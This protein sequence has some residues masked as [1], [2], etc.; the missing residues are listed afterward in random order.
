MAATTALRSVGMEERVPS[1]SAHRA[2]MAT[3]FLD[4]CRGL[5]A[6]YVVLSHVRYLLM[7][8]YGEGVAAGQEGIGWLGKASFAALLPFRYGHEA[9]LFFFILSGFVI[10]L[11]QA[12]GLQRDGGF[13]LGWRHYLWRRA[14]RLYPPLLLAIVVSYMLDRLG[15]GLGFPIYFGQTTSPLINETIRPAHDGWTLM[16]NLAFLMHCYVQEWG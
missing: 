16:G 11:R 15:M 5:A 13:Q 8:G 7:A 10:H 14:R 6:L 3:D 4:G 12:K 9:V 1:A 2:M